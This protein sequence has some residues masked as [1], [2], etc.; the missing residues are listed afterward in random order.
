[1][2]A[3][4]ACVSLRAVRRQHLDEAIC[5]RGHACCP[6]CGRT[7]GGQRPWTVEWGTEYCTLI[8]QAKRQL[9]PARRKMQLL[10]HQQAGFGRECLFCVQRAKEHELVTEEKE[11]K[12][13]LLPSHCV[14]AR[15]HLQR[16]LSVFGVN[17]ANSLPL[18][19]GKKKKLRDVS[20]LTKCG[21]LASNTLTTTNERK[22]ISQQRQRR[23]SK[24]SPL[25]RDSLE[26]GG[27]LFS[28]LPRKA[29]QQ[30]AALGRGTNLCMCMRTAPAH[31][32][33]SAAVRTPPARH[34]H[35][36]Q[37]TRTPRNTIFPPTPVR[38]APHTPTRR[39]HA[40]RI[41]VLTVVGPLPVEPTPRKQN[42]CIV[43]LD[44]ALNSQTLIPSPRT[45]PAPRRRL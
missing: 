29:Q 17:K 30:L 22:H 31:L 33:C 24:N 20:R 26:K 13:T 6:G 35:G 34:P 1:M 18:S 43:L 2:S 37:A 41:R 23:V 19:R 36:P 12:P 28:I 10:S 4:P 38:T 7:A 39:P 32:C 3:S 40:A 11:E 44:P 14:N 8:L 42:K 21:L 45:T 16:G 5:P 9:L 27:I 15:L 25:F